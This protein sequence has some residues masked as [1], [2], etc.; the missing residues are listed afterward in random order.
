PAEEARLE[1]TL[2]QKEQEQELRRKAKAVTPGLALHQQKAE[3]AAT[4]AVSAAAPSVAE[5]ASLLKDIREK[6]RR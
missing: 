4:S 6:K 2:A 5:R 1:R 3:Q